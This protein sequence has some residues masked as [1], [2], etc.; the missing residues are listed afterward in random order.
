HFM[1]TTDGGGIAMTMTEEELVEMARAAEAN[2]STIILDDPKLIAQLEVGHVKDYI[3]FRD[4]TGRLI[5][6]VTQRLPGSPPPE[7]MA[8]LKSL[9]PE[10]RVRRLEER[11]GKTLDEVLADFRAR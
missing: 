7:V 5:L 4:A 6:V 1:G 3:H 11:T 8:R 10:E 2:T 9:S